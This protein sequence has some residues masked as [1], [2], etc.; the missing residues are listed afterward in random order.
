MPRGLTLSVCLATALAGCGEADPA[1][2][3]ARGAWRLVWSDEFERPENSGVDPAKWIYDLGTGYPGGPQ[4]WGTGEIETMTDRVA[5]VSHDGAG[6]LRITPL[7]APDGAWTSGRIE[8]RRNDFAPPAGGALA[9][10]ASIRQPDVD[11]AEG[12]GYWP[13][14]WMLGGPYRGNHRNWPEVGEIDLLE[15]ANGRETVVFTFH[16]GATIPGPCNEPVGI[17]S[18]ERPCPGCRAGFHVYRAEWDESTSPAEIRWYLDGV[19]QH[20]VRQGE[21]VDRA[22][23]AAATGHGYMLI[24]NVAMGGGLAEAFGGGPTPTTVPGRPMLIDYVRVYER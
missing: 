15:A 17:S 24:L 6:R 7:R 4:R 5:N 20:V 13:A 16:C 21:Q 22:S 23:W 18:G 11:P 14:F 3:S 12:M 9:V 1:R 10:E 8:T 19:L 2:A